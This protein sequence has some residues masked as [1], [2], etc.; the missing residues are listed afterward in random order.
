MTRL[1]VWDRL[2]R[3]SAP[4]VFLDL[5]SILQVIAPLAPETH[6]LLRD[7]ADGDGEWFEFADDEWTQ[8]AY[9]KARLVPTVELVKAAATMPQAIWA[10]FAGFRAPEA[11]EP[12]IVLSALDSSFWRIETDDPAILSMVRTRFSDVRED[13]Y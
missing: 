6:W 7:F 12:W 3:H 9:L 8:G 13:G 2:S 5:A 10:Q 11:D 1:S 4:G